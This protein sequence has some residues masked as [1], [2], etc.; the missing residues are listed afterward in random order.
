MVEISTEVDNVCSK[1]VVLSVGTLL[2]RS[3]TQLLPLAEHC[4]SYPVQ[5][6]S[7]G[8]II[9]CNGTTQ[10]EVY[11]RRSSRHILRQDFSRIKSMKG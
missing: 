2:P 8:A 3:S 11:A 10:D 4:E 7:K 5:L 9:Q 1:F 6:K